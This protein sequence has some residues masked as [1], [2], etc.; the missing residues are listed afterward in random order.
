MI[1][2]NHVF[3]VIIDEAINV[4]IGDDEERPIPPPR[5]KRKKT[6]PLLKQASAEEVH[7]YVITNLIYLM[8]LSTFLSIYLS[9]SLSTYQSIYLPITL[10]TNNEIDDH[11]QLYM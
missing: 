2:V 9:I 10:S 1:H 5:R 6:H 3:I 7:V 4:K 11:F 8:Y